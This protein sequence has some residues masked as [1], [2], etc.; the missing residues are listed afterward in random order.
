MMA[1]S[2]NCSGVLTP[3]VPSP[4]ECVED[5]NTRAG[6]T[7]QSEVANGEYRF[8]AV[9]G[10][11]AKESYPGCSLRFGT[12]NESVFLFCI[13]TFQ[14]AAERLTRWSCERHGDVPLHPDQ[15]VA[16]AEV[17]SGWRLTI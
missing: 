14:A 13:R 8:A 5:W 12:G 4:E 1:G 9:R 16:R 11:V 6:S 3:G 17:I 2:V 10:W 7:V 15:S